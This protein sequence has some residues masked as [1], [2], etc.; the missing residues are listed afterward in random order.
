MSKTR[1]FAA[2][3]DKTDKLRQERLGHLS[4]EAKREGE[5]GTKTEE[6]VM[7][8]PERKVQ[9]I[10]EPIKK[11]VVVEKNEPIKEKEKNEREV[12]NEAKEKISTSK[13]VVKEEKT[14][15]KEGAGEK[16]F[17][18]S[19]RISA[20]WNQVLVYVQKMNKNKYKSKE[21]ILDE[22]IEAGISKIEGAKDVLSFLGEMKKKRE[23]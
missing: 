1:K 2:I 4:T 16:T 3:A 20:H 14:I 19:V 13:I 23:G 18:E 7:L 10:T 22:L 11:E 12:V 17:T 15:K 9:E 6:E 8:E 5:A 21:A